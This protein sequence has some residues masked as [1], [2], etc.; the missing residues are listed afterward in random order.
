V[1]YAAALKALA[2]LTARAQKGA[3]GLVQELVIADAKRIVATRTT[4]GEVL[5]AQRRAYERILKVLLKGF[6]ICGGN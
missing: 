6:L 4:I 1:A 2:T 3:E 5:S